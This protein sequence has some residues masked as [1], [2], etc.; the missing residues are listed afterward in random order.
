MRV[1]PIHCATNRLTRSQDLLAGSL[2]KRNKIFGK[3]N[4]VTVQNYKDTRKILIA[5]LRGKQLILTHTGKLFSLLNF[6]LSLLLDK[7][8][9]DFIVT[10][11]IK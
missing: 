1:A 7:F 6:H 5:L 3:L 10:I 2:E 4:N 11:P 9:H 8:H